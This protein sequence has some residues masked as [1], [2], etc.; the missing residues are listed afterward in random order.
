MAFD[1]RVQQGFDM[2]GQITAVEDD[3]ED[4]IRASRA[5][6]W[7]PLNW[8]SKPTSRA[9][10]ACSLTSV[11]VPL[12]PHYRYT[13]T[14]HDSITYLCCLSHERSCYIMDTAIGCV[15]Y[16]NVFLLSIGMQQLKLKSISCLALDYG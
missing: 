10:S 15:N 9:Q 4:I 8:L 13:I 1:V 7:P 11:A 2:R 6:Y 14:S 3:G 5:S 12:F 16:A